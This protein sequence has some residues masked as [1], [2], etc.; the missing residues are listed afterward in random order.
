MTK[1]KKKPLFDMTKAKKS[2]PLAQQLKQQGVRPS[3]KVAAQRKEVKKDKAPKKDE[4]K[5]ESKAADNNAEKPNLLL[6]QPTPIPNRSRLMLVEDTVAQK[7]IATV[8]KKLERNEVSLEDSIA[9]WVRAVVDSS[10]D[11]VQ[12]RQ[13]FKQAMSHAGD[14]L[15]VIMVTQAIKHLGAE[16]EAGMLLDTLQEDIVDIV[17]TP[18]MDPRV[19]VS[20]F[21][22]LVNWRKSRV[23]YAFTVAKLIQDTKLVDRVT[24]IFQNFVRLAESGS[25]E[26]EPM[27]SGLPTEERRDMA[28][29]VKWM[30]KAEGL[31]FQGIATYLE[32]TND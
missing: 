19:K 14:Q 1:D 12:V 2:K 32:N 27:L 11:F 13:A 18:A 10:I 21:N 6:L 28:L 4:T 26:W 16:V 22:A 30:L 25:S 24:D 20:A 29:V 23:E 17:R 9:L 15:E 5:P 31:D 8:I 7:Q 3:E